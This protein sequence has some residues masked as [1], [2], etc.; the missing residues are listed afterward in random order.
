MLS[1]SVWA[2]Q[3]M[4]K[5]AGGEPV[6]GFV[7]SLSFICGEE[8]RVQT[9]TILFLEPDFLL[10]VF[11]LLMW[12]P[13]SLMAVCGARGGGSISQEARGEICKIQESLL[14]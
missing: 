6:S 3:Q 4:G 12:K 13:R 14:L 7:I 2:D 8:M 1:I 5:K 11:T 10:F 9:V